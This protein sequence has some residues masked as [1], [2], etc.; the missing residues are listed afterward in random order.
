MWTVALQKAPSCSQ[1]RWQTQEASPSEIYQLHLSFNKHIKTMVGRKMWRLR[2]VWALIVCGDGRLLARSILI[3]FY[4]LKNMIFFF[5]L[6]QKNVTTECT[7]F[8]VNH[9]DELCLKLTQV[10]VTLYSGEKKVYCL[11]WLYQWIGMK[12]GWRGYLIQSIADHM[13]RHIYSWAI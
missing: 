11:H 7:V 10:M 5:I 6:E 3:H 8:I 2:D 1:E 13:Q 12:M 4:L 9:N